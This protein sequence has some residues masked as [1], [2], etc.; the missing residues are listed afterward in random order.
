MG[1]LWHR[2]GQ[3]FI[4]FVA[5]LAAGCAAGGPQPSDT[6][7]ANDWAA[8]ALL[9]GPLT[10][11]AIA[12]IIAALDNDPRI[13]RLEL[14]VDSGGGFGPAGLALAKRIAP[15]YTTVIVNGA[16]HSACALYLL[17][18][19]DRIQI[20]PGSSVVLHHDAIAWVAELLDHD[21]P[22]PDGFRHEAAQTLAFYRAHS[23]D[24]AMIDCA[25]MASLPYGPIEQHAEAD[26][27]VRDGV[28]LYWR[29]T[30]NNGM[31]LDPPALFRFLGQRKRIEGTRNLIVREQAGLVAPVYCRRS[32]RP[33][34]RAA[35]DYL[36]AYKAANPVP[37]DQP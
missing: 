9:R 14:T 1:D 3:L 28:P 26:G 33:W 27:P 31:L 17:P 6:D 11:E 37:S 22:V 34:F 19:A 21:M 30:R 10:P 32:P 15:L 25:V 8:A 7:N 4:G 13:Q 29:R 24:L 36:D 20:E 23:V 12:P 16:C 2:T 5:C 18:V 35:V